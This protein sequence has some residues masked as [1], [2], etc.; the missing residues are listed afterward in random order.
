MYLYGFNIYVKSFCVF[1]EFNVIKTVLLLVVVVTFLA[2]YVL[3]C[4]DEDVCLALQN[5]S[6]WIISTI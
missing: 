4:A 2:N 1:N 6:C 5:I 3:A